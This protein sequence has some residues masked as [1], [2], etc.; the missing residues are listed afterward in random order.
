MIGTTRLWPKEGKWSLYPLNYN[1]FL[2]EKG[3][4]RKGVTLVKWIKKVINYS[5]RAYT[6]QGDSYYL[7]RTMV[8]YHPFQMCF[9]NLYVYQNDL[10]LHPLLPSGNTLAK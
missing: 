7:E 9:S 3:E 10:K 8:E 5:K 1:G 4:K 2:K 6:N